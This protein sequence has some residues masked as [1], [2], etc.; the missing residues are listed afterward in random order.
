MTANGVKSKSS[1]YRQRDCRRSG[2][3]PR[4]VTMRRRNNVALPIVFFLTILSLGNAQ[5]QTGTPTTQAPSTAATT[6][7]ASAGQV[8]APKAAPEAVQSPDSDSGTFVFRKQVEEVVLHATVID[9][10][11]HIITSLDRG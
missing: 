10:K 6:P 3:T 9:D 2:S 8:A 7:P 5:T 1:F 11:Q 4:R